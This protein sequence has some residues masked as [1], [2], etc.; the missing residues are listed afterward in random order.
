MAETKRTLKKEKR[1]GWR[2][3][4]STISPQS[5]LSRIWKIIKKFKNRYI[6]SNSPEIT[7]NN[8]ILTDIQEIISSL[9]P[10]STKNN[11]EII[12]NDQ[13]NS[14]TCTIFNKPFTIE[15]L[16]YVIHNTKK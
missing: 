11:I 8:G 7:S 16:Y 2:E 3:F 10:P 9:C 6:G 1:Q 15:E 14:S 4:C 12:D 5:K 13:G